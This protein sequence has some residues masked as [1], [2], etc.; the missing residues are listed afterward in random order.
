MAVVVLLL[1][2]LLGD[3]VLDCVTNAC[4][5]CHRHHR[6]RRLHMRRRCGG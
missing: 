4:A 2:L 6:T 1:L 5:L 3:A